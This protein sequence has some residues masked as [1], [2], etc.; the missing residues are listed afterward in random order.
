MPRRR[1]ESSRRGWPGPTEP[2][3]QRAIDDVDDQ[4][5]HLGRTHRC[6]QLGGQGLDTGSL[7]TGL[8]DLL[9]A[10]TRIAGAATFLNNESNVNRLDKQIQKLKD[11]LPTAIPTP[12]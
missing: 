7:V 11:K 4:E 1:P 12:S 2:A 6:Y 5:A 9:L 3:S 8:L 10:G